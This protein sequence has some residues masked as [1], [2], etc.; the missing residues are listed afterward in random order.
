MSSLF[1]NIDML[2]EKD[3]KN[4]IALNNKFSDQSGTIVSNPKDD[5]EATLKKFINIGILIEKRGFNLVN[6]S[7][8]AL[9]KTLYSDKLLNIINEYYTNLSK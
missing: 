7:W 2:N 4:F 6:P 8:I 5:K 3:F 9:S 1:V